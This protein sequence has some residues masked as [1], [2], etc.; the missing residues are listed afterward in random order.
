MN[1]TKL[2]ISTLLAIILLATQVMA[3]GAAPELQEDTP[4][5]GTVE[6]ITLETDAETGVTT[7]VV[8]LTDESGATQTVRLSVED[9]TLL[10]L[11][12]DDGTGSPIANEA[13]IGETVEI[14][15]TT[16]IT[17]DDEK[18]HP[19]GSAISDFFSALLGVDY[20]SI[21]AFHEDGIGFGVIA[22]ALWMTNALEGG[23]ELFGA[24]LDA[25]QS[26]D[27]SAVTLTDGSTP[28]N[29]GQF[30]QAV[31]SDRE[32]SKENLGA[33]KSGR[34]NNDQDDGEQAETNDNESDESNGNGSDKS[35]NGNGS[36]KSNGNDPD[37]SNDNGA[38]ES[39]CKGSDKS[40]NGNG[41]DNTNC[42]GSD[43]SNGKGKNNGKGKGHK[44]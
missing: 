14:D 34:A 12:T 8:S 4:I 33:I 21:M 28:T 44:K 39:N 40:N 22:Q 24:I 6:S 17:S 31:M 35:N 43:N 37:N 30:R 3:V 10:G 42:N 23:T 15:P 27:Y 1:R 25:K 26:G 41:S 18:E 16:V 13:A 11:V 29:W 5:T 38:D 19:V 20:D 36:D 2:S 32:K 7:V 9:A